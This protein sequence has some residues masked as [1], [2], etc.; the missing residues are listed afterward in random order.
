MEYL[1]PLCLLT[2]LLAENQGGGWDVR[3]GRWPSWG[4][5]GPAK[6]QACDPDSPALRGQSASVRYASVDAELFVALSY[7]LGHV[8][9]SYYVDASCL[10]A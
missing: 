6:K 9:Q 8:H 4:A 10:T 7:H 2:F 5:W 3:A 1:C